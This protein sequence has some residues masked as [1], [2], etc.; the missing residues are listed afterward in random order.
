M[1]VAT[2]CVSVEGGAPAECRRC[3]LQRPA[4]SEPYRYLF[5]H[6]VEGTAIEHAMRQMWTLRLASP[7][8]NHGA[9]AGNFAR[10][11][12]RC[13]LPAHASCAHGPVGGKLPCPLPPAG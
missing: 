6:L 13:V 5:S 11:G 3:R 10:N 1:C 2:H 9:S 12:G 4:I 8:V 7:W